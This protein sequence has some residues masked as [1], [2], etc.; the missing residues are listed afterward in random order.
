MPS[1]DEPLKTAATLVGDLTKQVITLSSAFL[2][3]TITFSK[4]LLGVIDRPGF[5]QTA[6]ILLF[7][8]V[9]SGL[10]VMMTLTGRVQASS[11][12]S[13]LRFD[14]SLR[15]ASIVQILLFLGAML[16]LAVAGWSAIGKVIP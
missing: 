8:S 15:T 16:A 6:W 2:T 5:L 13:P 4:D 3:V 9:V 11:D 7:V 12:S 14:G 1:L 10:I